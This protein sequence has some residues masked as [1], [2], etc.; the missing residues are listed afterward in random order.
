MTSEIVKKQCSLKKGTLNLAY[1]Q[2]LLF[3]KYRQPNKFT[4]IKSCKSVRIVFKTQSG[5]EF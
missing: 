2:G 5:S 3:E 1:K 4:T